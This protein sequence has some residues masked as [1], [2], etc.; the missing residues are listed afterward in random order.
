MNVKSIQVALENKESAIQIKPGMETIVF[1]PDVK[2]S[3]KNERGA[4]IELTLNIFQANQLSL[5]LENAL[6]KVLT[7]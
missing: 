6:G 1:N 4:T 3:F 7:R 2:L 5:Q